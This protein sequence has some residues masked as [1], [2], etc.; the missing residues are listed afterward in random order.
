MTDIYGLGGSS[1]N[2]SSTSNNT[3]GSNSF[4]NGGYNSNGSHTGNNNGLTTPQVGTTMPTIPYSPLTPTSISSGS[5]VTPAKNFDNLQV[6]KQ[7]LTKL[8]FSC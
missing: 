6:I 8:K 5:F 7:L 1:S 3:T 4:L 2:S